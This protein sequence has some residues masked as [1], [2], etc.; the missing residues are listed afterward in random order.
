MKE[1]EDPWQKAYDFAVEVARI[2][3][4]VGKV[5]VPGWE[6]VPLNILFPSGL[7]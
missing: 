3:G 2:A 1:M 5:R 6:W 4:E 7:V